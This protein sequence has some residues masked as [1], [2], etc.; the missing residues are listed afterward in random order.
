MVG[1]RRSKDRERSALSSK[2]LD[3]QPARTCDKHSYLTLLSPPFCNFG[4]VSICA[5]SVLIH[6]VLLPFGVVQG[7]RRRLGRIDL[8]LVD[9]IFRSHPEGEILRSSGIKSECRRTN[10]S[11]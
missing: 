9:F 4:L 11:K 7:F 6:I 1:W 3:C 10:K 2:I 8:A 5:T